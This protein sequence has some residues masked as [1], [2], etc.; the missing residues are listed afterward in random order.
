MLDDVL[1]DMPLLVVEVDEVP[2]EE[3][4]LGSLHPIQ[5]IADVVARPMTQVHR[6]VLMMSLS[7]NLLKKCQGVIA[8]DS[9]VLLELPSGSILNTSQKGRRRFRIARQGQ[10]LDVLLFP[11]PD[12]FG[13]TMPS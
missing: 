12:R 4:G 3:L 7:L 5:C 13:K 6:G 10:H 9:G 1:L 11:R 8:L 2:E